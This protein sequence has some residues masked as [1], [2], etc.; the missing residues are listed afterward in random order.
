MEKLPEVTKIGA[1]D[2]QVC[3]PADWTDE[4]VKEF[5][6][7][8][9]PCGTDFGWVIRKQGSELLNGSG[10]RVKCAERE[11]YVHIMLDA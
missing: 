3:I 5:A 11:G 1:L 8:E 4:Q 6:D 2:M 10:E 9:N 7:K